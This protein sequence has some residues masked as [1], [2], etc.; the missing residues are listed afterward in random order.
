MANLFARFIFIFLVMRLGVAVHEYNALLVVV[1]GFAVSAIWKW[2]DERPE[3]PPRK[4]P[5]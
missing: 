4:N 5:K 3:V 1:L 2:I